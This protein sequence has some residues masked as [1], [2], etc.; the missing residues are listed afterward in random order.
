MPMVAERDT[1][2]ST[3]SSVN[4]ASR[5]SGAPDTVKGWLPLNAR[6]VRD[7]TS[8]NACRQPAAARNTPSVLPAENAVLPRRPRVVVVSEL[9][10]LS[11]L[12]A[13]KPPDSWK[14]R[15]RVSDHATPANGSS[16]ARSATG[17]A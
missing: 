3:P 4:A 8:P 9:R 7:S 15:V 10:L 1:A 17:H 12:N 11:P 6:R 16:C 5:A 2:I 14:P 13:A